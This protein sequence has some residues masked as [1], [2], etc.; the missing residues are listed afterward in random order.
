MQDKERLPTVMLV[1]NSVS[2]TGALK[3]AIQQALM[4]QDICRYVL[5][6]PH[7]SS[8]V[9]Y[10]LAHGVEVR[11]LPFL[12]LRSNVAA[13]LRYPFWL[14]ANTRLLCALLRKERASTLVMNDYYNLLGACVK[15]Q[16]PHLRLVT[17]VRFL[18]SMMPSLL[19]RLWTAAALRYADCIVAVSEAVRKQLPS[20]SKVLRLYDALCTA[21]KYGAYQVKHCVD[22]V[23][24]LYLCN[25]IQG[26]G[27]DFALRAF[28]LAYH[29]DHRLRLTFMGS[30]M[31]LAKNEAFKASLE[32]YVFDRGL[33]AVVDF[34]P[35]A[36]DVERA[37]KS[38]DIFLNFSEAESFSMTCAEA[39]FYGLP[40]I[41]SLCGGPAEIIVNG[42]TGL[43]LPN[44]DVE[45]FAEAIVFLANNEQIRCEYSVCSRNYVKNKFDP[46]IFKDELLS[47]LSIDEMK[48]QYCSEYFG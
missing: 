36:I 6:L 48:P 10:V 21:D 13:V 8:A 32:Q 2:I 25:Y 23:S 33:T 17:F 14:L 42:Q 19:N 16:I 4:L 29:K 38:A 39:A 34:L 24:L 15:M 20:S 40:T 46:Q 41:A 26:K 30:T 9:N 22:K 28:E 27:Q 18:P 7:H 1:D 44:K 11:T 47:I 12:E 37:Y 31:G 5:V 43:L 45:G 3:C 35:F